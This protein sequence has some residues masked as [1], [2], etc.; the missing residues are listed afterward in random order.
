MNRLASAAAV[1]LVSLAAVGLAGCGTSTPEAK[2]QGWI[3]KAEGDCS[4]PRT[5]L[6]HGVAYVDSDLMDKGVAPKIS[7]I[8]SAEPLDDIEIERGFNPL[9][10]AEA[11]N[12]RLYV[13]KD[14][15]LH[16][17]G[18]D[19]LGMVHPSK[20]CMTNVGE[21]RVDLELTA[22]DTGR[23]QFTVRPQGPGEGEEA[24]PRDAAQ[25]DVELPIQWPKK[26]P[27]GLRERMV[28]E[29]AT[30]VSFEH[31]A[32]IAY[33]GFVRDVKQGDVPGV[34]K[35]LVRDGYSP[36]DSLLEEMVFG[37]PASREQRDGVLPIVTAL[38]PESWI[39]TR[40]ATKPDVDW[41][42]K[43]EVCAPGAE[44]KRGVITMKRQPDGRW[45]VGGQGDA[46]EAARTFGAKAPPCVA[47][48]VGAAAAS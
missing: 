2:V 17:L 18:N 11:L 29:M 5:E 43:L 28:A 23:V 14:F 21:S 31:E 8:L 39:F 6:K 40:E 9:F 10:G 20:S 30:R 33:L 13:L 45:L 47:G 27:A 44:P 1:S 34:E 25:L 3:E 48:F 37:E 26:T 15:P 35:R 12:R 32:V 46:D 7:V 4:L 24:G 36:F 22:F 42:L 16:G 41:E 38:E 19:E